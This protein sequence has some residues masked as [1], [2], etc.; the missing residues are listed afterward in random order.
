[1]ALVLLEVLGVSTAAAK[2]AMKEEEEEVSNTRSEKTSTCTPSDSSSD[3]GDIRQ[4]S[5]GPSRTILYNSS[6]ELT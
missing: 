1:M 5:W 2:P 6:E 3:L 4:S